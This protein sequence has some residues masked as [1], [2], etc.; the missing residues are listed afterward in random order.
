MDGKDCGHPQ[1][2][3]R[4][5]E[6]VEDLK[7]RKLEIEQSTDTK[8]K[9]I[10]FQEVKSSHSVQG[11]YNEILPL[12]LEYLD[13][14]RL[15]MIRSVCKSWNIEACR[16]LQ[17]V[18]YV[19]LAENQFE[20]FK[21]L[22]GQG[23][24]LSL[25]SPFKSLHVSGNNF[26]HEH[27]NSIVGSKEFEVTKFSIT[28]P[29][30]Y[31]DEHCATFHS[32]LRSNG[33]TL[34]HLRFN[35]INFRVKK[36]HIEKAYT[37]SPGSNGTPTS[38]TFVYYKNEV[39]YRKEWIRSTYF[40]CP[41]NS[42]ETEE[43]TIKLPALEY[44]GF[45]NFGTNEDAL[46]DEET[47]VGDVITFIT[48]IINSAPNLETLHLCRIDVR[49][50]EYIFSLSNFSQV[51]SFQAECITDDHL[52]LISSLELPKLR[53]LTLMQDER[54][55]GSLL[56]L[57]Q[58]T[59]VD[60]ELLHAI[61]N[62]SSSVISLDLTWN[63]NLFDF[64]SVRCPELKILRVKSS[65]FPL[66]NLEGFTT[67]LFPKLEEVA[68]DR[69]YP[70][71]CSEFVQ[72]AHNGVT[73]ISVDI[74]TRGMDQLPYLISSLHQKFPSV[75]SFA[76]RLG[77]DPNCNAKAM[78]CLGEYFPRLQSLSVDAF[79]FSGNSSACLGISEDNLSKVKIQEMKEEDFFRE[80]SIFKFKSL[81]KLVL[82]SSI[83]LTDDMLQ[84]GIS[85]ISNLASFEFFWPENAL[86]VK[87]FKDLQ[88]LVEITINNCC[89]SKNSTILEELFTKM[90]SLKC[91][92]KTQ[93]EF[94]TYTQF[95][96]L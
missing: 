10:C 36:Q 19:P 30:C 26:K 94:A 24:K 49:I 40:Q 8:P 71:R 29:G 59:V 70:Y 55:S 90:N 81:S 92:C 32:I 64:E 18:S 44:F 43:E 79:R 50:L 52:H 35:G 31:K 46:G 15:K 77:S 53:H 13:L 66:D 61:G 51:T 58:S 5:P 87:N 39:E 2:R 7:K 68:I 95:D 11:N 89:T 56:A 27:K 82:G 47:A 85:K 38:R 1:K 9:T 74:S 73:S 65:R 12:I 88:H 78:D 16:A 63:W 14:K 34:T 96:N 41:V 75:L 67:D 54:F 60:D 83:Q 33:E 20:A 42:G 76:I 22:Q 69:Y 6:V 23:E 86:S 80:V 72:E 21:K 4:K 62:F 45:S 3:K 91:G 37:G 57:N 17:R 28:E 93:R 84:F 48:D 25:P